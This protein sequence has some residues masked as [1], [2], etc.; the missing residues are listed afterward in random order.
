MRG[1]N[2]LT[3]RF[4]NSSEVRLEDLA[5]KP[6]REFVYLDEVSLLSLL[7]SQKGEITSTT[8]EQSASG[9][10]IE[11][12]GTV[13]IGTPYFTK[14]E[15][16]SRYQA[17]K[18]NSFQTSRKATVQSWFRDF[19]LLENLRL[20]EPPA[21]VR[22]AGS[23]EE[24]VWIDDPSLR[25]P[26]SAL[27]RGELVE[28]RVRLASDPVF[29][30]GTM[31][32]EMLGMVG[33]H[34][35]L[36]GG[37]AAA[38]LA[39]IS[40]LNKI[41]QRLLTGLIPI[42]SR[43]AD[44]VVVTIEGVEHVVHAGLIAG[45]EIEQRPLEIVGVTEQTGYWKDIRRVLFSD[46]EFTV[47]CRIA[48]GGLQSSWAPVKL[49]ELFLPVAPDMI[50]Q[51][52]AASASFGGGDAGAVQVNTNQLLLDAALHAYKMALAEISGVALTDEQERKIAEAISE[53]AP[54]GDTAT[55]QRAAFA[56]VAQR[57]ADAGGREIEPD[58][59]WEIRDRVRSEVGLPLF[60]ALTASDTTTVEERPATLDLERPRLLDVEVVAIY[61]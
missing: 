10:T 57:I 32:T 9:S 33:D 25:I 21:E 22:P 54:T 23:S 1:F 58:I 43:A 18:N 24:L 28:F 12:A 5:A 48:R 42:R 51:I 29:R 31:A 60:P 46:A 11:A 38:T 4:R 49:G 3:R 41:L 55:A 26:A 36:F 2:W 6:L 14:T 59:D 13:G 16:S 45:L 40:P 17:N 47:L 53:Y 61:W 20:I 30:L 8:S 7:A 19:H 44:Y 56:M 34:P 50:D 35:A 39:E 27:A 52:N 37:S 15:A